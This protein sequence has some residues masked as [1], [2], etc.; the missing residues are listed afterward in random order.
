MA[1]GFPAASFFCSLGGLPAALVARRP[2]AEAVR[3]R[4]W[5]GGSACTRGW[6]HEGAGAN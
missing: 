5:P 3:A 6:P 2:W 4:V 1:I